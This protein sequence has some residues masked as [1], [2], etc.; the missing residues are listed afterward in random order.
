MKTLTEVIEAQERCAT[1]PNCHFCYLHSGPICEWIRDA[2]HY[3][4]HLQEYYEMSREHH[5]PNPAL[6]WDELKAME[7][8]PV[9]IDGSA[10]CDGQWA[11]PYCFGKSGESEY[12]FF[13]GDQY[14]KEDMVDSDN[15]V[16]WQAYRK[17]RA[18]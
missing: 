13:W 5:E 17:E 15:G 1:Y 14:W 18:E 8:K 12:V 16:S 4:M 9:W 2:L 11:I 10:I 6:T 7:G 3:L